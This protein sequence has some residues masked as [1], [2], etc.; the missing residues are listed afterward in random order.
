MGFMAKLAANIVFVI[1]GLVAMIVVSVITFRV[2]KEARAPL[3]E[4]SSIEDYSPSFVNLGGDNSVPAAPDLPAADEVANSM[5][6]GSAEIFENPAAEMPP[7]PLPSEQEPT[8]PE[9]LESEEEESEDDE[10]SQEAE[11]PP[12]VPPI[13]E[14]GLPQGWTME[15]WAY[16]GEK[17]L[18]QNKGE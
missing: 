2:V 11:L 10:S 7:P 15:Q 12:G 1:A 9:S 17:W 14:E 8:S 16:Y 6:G 4:Y 18:E 5:Y 13:P 3:E